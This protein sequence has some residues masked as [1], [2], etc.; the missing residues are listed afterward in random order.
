VDTRIELFVRDGHADVPE[1][2]REYA[3]RRLAFALR[4]FGHR[5]RQV[6][7]RLVDQNGPRRGVDTRCSLTADL[8]DGRRVFV[9][10]RAAWPFAAITAAAARLGEALR[11]DGER[12]AIAPRRRCQDLARA[13]GS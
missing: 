1:E 8:A 7:V 9:E 5:V 2:V 11:R 10:A 12:H 13:A 3:H 6:T 4:R